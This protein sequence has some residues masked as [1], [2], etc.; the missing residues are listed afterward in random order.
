MQRYVIT[1]FYTAWRKDDYT[2][3]QR[4]RYINEIL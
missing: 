3:S 4:A 2:A 1:V